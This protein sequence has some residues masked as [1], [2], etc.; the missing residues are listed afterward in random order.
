[1]TCRHGHRFYII[2]RARWC[3]YCKHYLPNK[4]GRLPPSNDS[5][6][7]VEDELDAF[8]MAAYYT[9]ESSID[10]FDGPQISGPQISSCMD[11]GWAGDDSFECHP[12]SVAVGAFARHVADEGIEGVR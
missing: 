9:D 11:C 3:P 8:E 6:A 2:G 12:R 4:R 10:E 7:A 5:T 1:M